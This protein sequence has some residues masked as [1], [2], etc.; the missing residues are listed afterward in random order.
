MF[1]SLFGQHSE[2]IRG[3]IVF[4]V[5][6]A[7]IGVTAWLVRRFGAN[8]LG[9]GNARGRQPRL[10]V[11]DSAAVD[12]RRKLLLIRRDNVEHLLMIGGPTD[13]VVEQSIVRAQ[14][15][16]REA[17]Q[18][19]GAAVAD[20]LPRPIPLDDSVNW[21]L[22]PQAE[23]AP[24]RV[25][26][27]PAPLRPQ[28]PAAIDESALWQAAPQAEPLPRVVRPLQPPPPPAEDATR[29]QHAPQP[30]PVQQADPLVRMPRLAAGGAIEPV[31]RAQAARPE[32][33]ARSEPVV[34]IP[35]PIPP[36]EPP[37]ARPPQMDA[38]PQRQ[39]VRALEPVFVPP[40]QPAPA[41][42]PSDPASDEFDEVPEVHSQVTAERTA[43]H[44]TEPPVA[45]ALHEPPP[46]TPLFPAATEPVVEIA[47]A[48]PA[49]PPPPRKQAA[50]PTLSPE[51]DE[52]LAEMAQRLEAAL[53]GPVASTT[54]ARKTPPAHDRAESEVP[55]R[56]TFSG[57][58][59]PE[60]DTTAG[61]PPAPAKPKPAGRT[62]YAN[63]EE[64]MASLLGRPAAG[65]KG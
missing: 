59:A 5:V 64:E 18:V 29:W 38:A 28:R 14:S 3:I 34:Q 17:P 25:Q 27:E 11:I 56:A 52:N 16:A 43:L 46:A 61:E 60:R 35:R 8:R 19:R 4:L 30:A 47:A 48:E 22:Q 36:V 23:P 55:D 7:L 37:A 20:A 6:L 24:L 62:L 10:A 50:E 49:P 33:G 41:P 63:L 40:S 9:G 31:L 2:A 44:E 54:P 39:P 58:P 65:N 42:V 15:Q 45:A 13:V 57:A 12:S 21:P 53:R 26:G 51:A 32:T 1:E